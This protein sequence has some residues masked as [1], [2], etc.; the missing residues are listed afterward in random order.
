MNNN[1]RKQIDSGI[2]PALCKTFDLQENE[3]ITHGLG[4]GL[5]SKVYIP[6]HRFLSSGLNDQLYKTLKSNG[7]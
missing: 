6:L 4:M 3:Q 1:L 7:R 5:W 2:Y